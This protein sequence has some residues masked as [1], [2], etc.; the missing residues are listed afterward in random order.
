LTEIFGQIF[1]NFG[2]TKLPVLT[3]SGKSQSGGF[4]CQMRQI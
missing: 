2:L 4:C 1:K 3:K